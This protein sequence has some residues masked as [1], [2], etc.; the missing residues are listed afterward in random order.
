M[1]MNFK[2]LKTR[3]RIHPVF[4]APSILLALTNV[5]ESH[6]TAPDELP[7]RRNSRKNKTTT[8]IHRMKMKTDPTKLKLTAAFWLATCIT[9]LM[10]PVT[11]HA[12]FVLADFQDNTG[13]GCLDWPAFSGNGYNASVA[14]ITNTV[15]TNSYSDNLPI[16]PNIYSFVQ[17]AVPGYNQSLQITEAGNAQNL[18]LNLTAA[19]YQAFATNNL[20]SFTFSVPAG[21]YTGGYSQIGSITINC[22]GK[23]GYAT[24]PFSNTNLWSATGNTANDSLGTAGFMP[25]Y[26]FANG[27]DPEEYQTVTLN[28][29]SILSQ[30][31]N[32]GYSYLQIIFQSNNGGGAPDNFYIN[33]INLSQSTP[34]LTYTV[35]DFSTNGVNPYPPN[36][37]GDD[38]YAAGYYPYDE[39]GNIGV[40]WSEWY[41]VGITGVTF[42]PDVNVS[43]DTNANGAMAINFTWNG[44]A[45]DGYQQWLLWQGNASTYVPQVAGGTTGI[46]YPQYT[47]LECDVM[48]D[49]SSIGTTNANGVLGVIRLGIRGVGSF[50]ADWEPAADYTT[51]SDTNWHHLNMP[52][53]PTDP[54]SLNIAGPIIGE[55]VNAYVGGGG[56]DGNQILYVDNIRFTGP[57]GVVTLPPTVVS[58]PKKASPG[59]RI[60]AGSSVNTYDREILYTVDQNQSWV[61]PGATFPVSYSFSLQD[62]NPNIEQT[63]V[64]LMADGTAPTTAGEYDDYSGPTTLWLQLNPVANGVAA[65]VQWK[66]NL[67]GANPNVTATVFTNSTA[68]GVWSLVFTSTNTGYVVAP[69]Q[70]ILGSTN[71]TITDTNV[72]SDFADPAFAA[73]GLQPNTTTGEG[74]YEDWGMIKV[75]GVV[76]GTEFEDFT[77]EGSDI[78]ANVTPSGLFDNSI[79]ALPAST[80]IQTTN[81]VW[82][83]SWNQPALYLTL[84]AATNLLSTNWINPGWYSGYNDTN[85]PRVMPNTTPFGNNYWV[86]LPKDD[87]PTA[88]GSQNPSPP[89][90]GPSSLDAFFELSTNVVSP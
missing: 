66:T 16:Y 76:D 23:W 20:L 46:G 82:W 14:G 55:D 6:K 2:V 19:Q 43:G 50:G 62:Y 49:P 12:Q 32:N 72:V 63:M 56:L 78:V 64:E 29:S 9:W 36:A 7:P 89:A 59:L 57:L 60:F 86:L 26:Y 48:F 73:F 90:A 18:V 38:Y 83:L 77:K 11:S 30:I 3:V 24:V 39:P 53:N 40:I 37:P 10:M 75:T 4:C 68:V 65:S 41:G 61:D 31:T 13:D 81:D 8:Q 71:F 84:T 47:N 80:I 87:L 42:D 69:G 51:I 79:S 45:T 88:N 67:P 34:V 35:D 25:N 15:T 28:Y 52:L 44:P 74:A 54:N 1:I 5:E 33:N 70:V 17:G 27:D 58:D 85:A 22:N 21:T